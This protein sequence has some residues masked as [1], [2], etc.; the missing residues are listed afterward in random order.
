[1]FYE[2]IYTVALHFTNHFMRKGFS[3]F[4]FWVIPILQIHTTF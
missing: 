4:A 2:K 3:F 1:M